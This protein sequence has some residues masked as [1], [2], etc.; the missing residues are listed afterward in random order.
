[1]SWSRREEAREAHARTKR[2][3]SYRFEYLQKILTYD[4]YHISSGRR[5]LLMISRK[6]KE[7]KD[8]SLEHCI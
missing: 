6:N 2:T 3:L 7:M 5:I 1:V 8:A 4:N